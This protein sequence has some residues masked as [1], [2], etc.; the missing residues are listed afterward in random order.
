MNAHVR[1]LSY[2]LSLGVFVL[3][4]VDAAR[5]SHKAHHDK[6]VHEPTGVHHRN[7][8]DRKSGRHLKHV[9]AERHETTRP[10]DVSFPVADAPPLPGG[11]AAVKQAIDLDAQGQ[12]R[13]SDQ[14]RENARRSG[15]PASLSNGSS[16]DTPKP[17]RASAATQHSLPITRTG[18]ASACMRRR[19]EARLW[20]ERSDAATV[21]SFTRSTGERQRPLRAGPSPAGRGRP[22]RRRTPGPRGLAVGGIDG[23]HRDRGVRKFRDLLTRDDHRARMD[24]RIGAKDFAGAM[25]AARR[26][27]SDELSIV[28]ACAA[29]RTPTRRSSGSMTLRPR[30]AGSGLRALPHPAGRCA[31]TG[32]PRQPV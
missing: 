29:G 2:L 20:Q 17:T 19:A 23:A 6:A 28:K 24:K 32:L 1:W 12:D 18:R 21:H 8:A 27:G 30:P 5:A 7:S 15:G 25:R 9:R 11:L 4:S 26:L 31:T 16:C 22:R 14:H 10:G 13:R 3:C